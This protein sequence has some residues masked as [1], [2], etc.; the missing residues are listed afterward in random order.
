MLYYQYVLNEEG[1]IVKINS[2]NE[3]FVE[4]LI[5]EENVKKVK[6]GKTK[7]SDLE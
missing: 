3:P 2:S 1:F 6:L 5:S 4:K 7:P